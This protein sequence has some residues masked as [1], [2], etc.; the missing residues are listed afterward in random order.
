LGAGSHQASGGAGATNDP[1]SSPRAGAG[2]ARAGAAGSTPPAG[3]TEPSFAEA[4]GQP[5]LSAAGAAE[6][7]NLSCASV[8]DCAFTHLGNQ[9][10]FTACANSI[11]VSGPAVDS[12]LSTADAGAPASDAAECENLGCFDVFDCAIFHL[13]NECAFTACVNFICVK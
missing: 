12:N 3:S 1:S 6:C 11:C 13:G 8:F 5:E 10:A 7:E 9:C 2:D 4:P